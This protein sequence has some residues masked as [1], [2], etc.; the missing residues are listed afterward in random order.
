M[1]D[2]PVTK[3]NTNALIAALKAVPLTAPIGGL[4]RPVPVTPP[5]S[6][7]K[8]P[9]GMVAYSALS[10]TLV[11]AAF[12]DGI[13]RE[14]SAAWDRVQRMRSVLDKRKDQLERLAREG[15]EGIGGLFPF[16]RVALIEAQ[17]PE[18]IRARAKFVR[19]TELMDRIASKEMAALKQLAEQHRRAREFIRMLG[20][21]GALPAYTIDA[22]DNLR[23]VQPNAWGNAENWERLKNERVFR[24]GN[25]AFDPAGVPCFHQAV[26]DKLEAFVAERGESALGD[27]HGAMQ[28]LGPSTPAVAEVKALPVQHPKNKRGRPVSIGA[29]ARDGIERLKSKGVDIDKMGDKKLARA[30]K[31]IGVEVSPRTAGRQKG[32]Q[33]SDA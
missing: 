9:P 4:A 5:T 19:D 25:E 23:P 21:Q 8:A 10:R 13:T 17:K 27:I 32:A 14:V 20:M 31:A 1:T 7:P 15:T 16:A 6:L 28:A 3:Q 18:V 33:K 2:I 12:G 26:V 30:L 11:C 24:P 29:E 22:A